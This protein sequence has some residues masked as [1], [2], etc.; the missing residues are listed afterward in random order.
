MKTGGK[1]NKKRQ[2]AVSN[3]MLEALKTWRKHLKLTP[4]LPTQADKNPLLPKLIGTGS[5]TDKYIFYICKK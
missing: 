3:T 4:L 2:I 1:G 5:I